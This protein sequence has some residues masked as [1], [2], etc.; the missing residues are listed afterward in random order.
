MAWLPTTPP[1]LLPLREKVAAQRSDEGSRH[2]NSVLQET[3]NDH[4]R[5]TPHPSPLPQGE[6]GQV[7]P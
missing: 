5:A 2:A 3:A 6:R 4:R 1:S 7:A